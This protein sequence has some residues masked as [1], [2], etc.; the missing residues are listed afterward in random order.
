MKSSP[1]L[2]RT[3]HGTGTGDLQVWEGQG[4]EVGLPVQHHWAWEVGS[5][6]AP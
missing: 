3:G 2:Q 6:L 1:S 4:R 5:N